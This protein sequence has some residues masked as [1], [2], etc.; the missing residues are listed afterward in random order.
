MNEI[1]KIKEAIKKYVG[2]KAQ[3]GFEIAYIA[4][5]TEDPKAVRL[6]EI[7][8]EATALNYEADSNLDNRRMSELVKEAEDLVNV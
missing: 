6:M 2:S 5:Q 8:Q 4:K 3:M 7:Y 1:I